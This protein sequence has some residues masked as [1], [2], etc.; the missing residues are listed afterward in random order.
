MVIIQT[1]TN[2]ISETCSC[3][4]TAVLTLC[5]NYVHFSTWQSDNIHTLCQLFTSLYGDNNKKYVHYSF[6]QIIL[7]NYYAHYS[8]YRICKNPTHYSV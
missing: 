4:S 3:Y 2:T 5:K 7:Q 1:D 6:C 8:P